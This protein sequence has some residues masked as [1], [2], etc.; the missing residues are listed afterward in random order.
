[1]HRYTRLHSDFK[2][3]LPANHELPLHKITVHILNPMRYEPLP[4]PPNIDLGI[5]KN[6]W[7]TQYKIT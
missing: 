2:I 3:Y 7:L 1:M 6:S 4:L 5:S